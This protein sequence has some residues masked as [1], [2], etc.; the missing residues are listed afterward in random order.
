MARGFDTA[1]PLRVSTA[2]AFREQGYMFAGRYLAPEGSWKRLTA[3]EAR[4]ITDAGLYIVSLFERGASRAAEGTAAGVEDGCTALRLAREVGQPEGSAIYFA[5][6]YDAQPDDHDAIEAYMRAADEQLPGYELEAYGSYDVIRMLRNR[7]VIRPDGGMQTYAWSRGKLIA[8][9]RIYQG[10]ND[11]FVNDVGIDRCES[12][13]D[14]GGWKAG[15]AITPIPTPPQPAI[16]KEDARQIRAILSK[17]WHEMDG[18]KE[19]QDYTHHLVCEVY[20]AA[21]MDVDDD[22]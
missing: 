4:I 9:P 19:V 22:E 17:Y 20:K 7:G 10:E 1:T 18:N 12:N 15:M 8:A 3:A 5:V 14:A 13:G 6:D 11:V 16:S 21:G 2:V